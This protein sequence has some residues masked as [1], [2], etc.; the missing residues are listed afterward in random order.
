MM[1]IPPLPPTP[2]PTEDETPAGGES[3]QAGPKRSWWRSNLVALVALVVLV[4]ATATTV[5]YQE[6]YQHF[7]FGARAVTAVMVPD[8]ES[9]E[10]LGATWGPLRGGE[11]QDLSGLDVPDD[12]RLLAVAVPV[13]ASAEGI[14]CETPKLVEQSTGREW[15]P[16]RLEIGLLSSSDEP[17]R[18]LSAES[19]EYEMIV[20]F[21]VPDDAEGP[22]W[23]DV[24]LYDSGGEFLRFSF[25]P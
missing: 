2:P 1:T 7:G 18:C 3:V 19:G 6:W 25:E 11:V 5:G 24:F 9:V 10:R 13:D 16:V 15:R 22:F 20:P 4:P 12:T 23:V 8:D 21:V 17:E 14:A